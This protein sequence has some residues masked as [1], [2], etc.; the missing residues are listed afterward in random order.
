MYRKNVSR[1]VR[2]CIFLSA[3]VVT[4]PLETA[5]AA[6][7]ISGPGGS[8]TAGS[9]SLGNTSLTPDTD[10][11]GHTWIGGPDS[12]P[13][14]FTWQCTPGS[15]VFIRFY[16][17]SNIGTFTYGGHPALVLSSSVGVQVQVSGNE[18]AGSS[19]LYYVPMTASVDT[20]G[21]FGGDCGVTHL[22]NNG[23]TPVKEVKV[24]IREPM[25]GYVSLNRSNVFYISA[26]TEDA[27]HTNHWIDYSFSGSITAPSNCTIAPQTIPIQLGD[28]PSG[29][30][31]TGG[32]GNVPSG[33]TRKTVHIPVHCVGGDISTATISMRLS[34]ST[35]TGHPEYLSTSNN[36][37]G[38]NVVDESGTTLK[39]NNSGST[40]PYHLDSNGSAT[41]TISAEPIFLGGG[42]PASGPFS[43][44]ASLITTYP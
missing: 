21:H 20:L 10:V 13:L 15:G 44:T 25:K 43:A 14:Y 36:R 6:T 41:I 9:I 22:W 7:W 38:V 1:I 11:V 34:G 42:T 5:T 31:L 3:V 35:A 40:I 17:G 39:P 16:S 23:N 30:F 33:V 37:I 18:W 4:M 19:G 2:A 28:I 8:P 24:I 27:L 32:V 29:A 26:G 12:T